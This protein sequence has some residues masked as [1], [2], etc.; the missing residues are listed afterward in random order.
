MGR[1]LEQVG[2]VSV[3]DPERDKLII[4]SLVGENAAWIVFPEGCMVKNRKV[5]DKG[6]F[7]ITADGDKYP[8]RTGAA[9]LAWRAEIL[10][11]RL[12]ALN[13]SDPEGFAALAAEFDLSPEFSVAE[14]INIVPVNVSYYPLHFTDTILSRFSTMLEDKLSLRM[15]EEVVVESSMLLSGVDIDIRF[16]QILPVAPVVEK[17]FG[18]KIPD[19]VDNKKSRQVLKKMTD[20]SMAAI[21]G[22]AT[23]NLD[24]LLAVLLYK[25]SGRSFTEIDFRRRAYLA[26]TA[27]GRSLAFFRHQG[28]K[29][30][31][32]DLLFEKG[33]GRIVDILGLALEKGFLQI[34]GEVDAKAL[35][36]QARLRFLEPEEDVCSDAFHRVRLDNPFLVMANAIEPLPA[37][38]R[39]LQRLSLTPA[40]RLRRLTARRIL[41]L[42]EQVY[43]D[44]RK[45]FQEDPELCPLAAGTPYLVKKRRAQTGIVL[46]HDWLSTPQSLKGLA[47][48]LGQRGFLVLVPRLPGHAT[49][50]ADLENRDYEEWQRAVD[51]AYVYVSGLCRKVVVCGVGSSVALA[52][53]LAARGHEMMALIAIFPVFGVVRQ[54]LAELPVED[55]E[56]DEETAPLTV[57]FQ[58]DCSYTS[59][60]DLSQRQ[61][62]KMLL[63]AAKSLPLVETPLLILQASAATKADHQNVYKYLE[64]LAGPEKELLLLPAADLSSLTTGT[65]HGGQALVDFILRYCC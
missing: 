26:A 9:A 39:L 54:S 62:K 65:S 11:R 48:Y 49:V 44:D 24:H 7:M 29:K 45:S 63:Q 58:T 42:M 20:D 19:F 17:F 34:S 8:P 51:E 35:S 32:V 18:R 52:L 56:A 6:S 57:S 46:I 25:S 12:R 1:Y 28:L 55:K 64:K 27:D 60:P 47:D 37:L 43:L 36:P 10:R 23:V 41:Q 61:V 3:G 16:G 38:Q 13:D 40:W 50:A 15:L 30:S 31:Q 4:K 59:F 22:L 14:S 21:Y 5:V 53:S 2:A 33:G